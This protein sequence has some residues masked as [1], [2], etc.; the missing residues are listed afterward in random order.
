MKLGI[1]VTSTYILAAYAPYH[2]DRVA[3]SGR[4]EICIGYKGAGEAAVS[5][6]IILTIRIDIKR[7]LINDALKL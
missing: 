6:L 5:A 4:P 3:S 2:L 7:A 1:G